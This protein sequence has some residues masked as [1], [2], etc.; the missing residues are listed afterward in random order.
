MCG[1]PLPS[2]VELDVSATYSLSRLGIAMNL[3]NDSDQSITAPGIVD[4]AFVNGARIVGFAGTPA[5]ELPD[6]TLR[7]GTVGVVEV[8]AIPLD[9]GGQ[10]LTNGDYD[11]AVKLRVT[12]GADEEYTLLMATATVRD[13]AVTAIR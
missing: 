9:C 1:G 6:V 2:A 8:G 11:F 7:P 10:S 3:R 4:A 5:I 13:G 12:V